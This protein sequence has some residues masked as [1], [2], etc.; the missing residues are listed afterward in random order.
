[1]IRHREQRVALIGLLALGTV[2]V[3]L[4]QLRD[5]IAFR[6]YLFRSRETIDRAREQI[7]GWEESYKPA[8]YLT[9]ALKE[10]DSDGEIGFRA[11]ATLLDDED[12]RV[13]ARTVELIYHH[14]SRSDQ[15]LGPYSDLDVA[16]D[17]RSESQRSLLRYLASE[18]QQRGADRRAYRYF[19]GEEEQHWCWYW[20]G[21]ENHS[22]APTA[23]GID[24]CEEVLWDEFSY[25]G[26]Y[27]EPAKLKRRILDALA[28]VWRPD[29]D[30]DLN[31]RILD[32]LQRFVRTGQDPDLRL[33]TLNRLAARCGV[34][35][36]ERSPLLSDW[37]IVAGF[38]PPDA[39]V[40][41]EAFPFRDEEDDQDDES[42]WAD[43]RGLLTAVL[44]L[45]DPRAAKVVTRLAAERGADAIR[46]AAALAD[47]R[48]PFPKP[49]SPPT[50]RSDENRDDDQVHTKSGSLKNLLQQSPAQGEDAR[51]SE[52][53]AQILRSGERAVLQSVVETAIRKDRPDLVFALAESIQRFPLRKT[54]S[55]MYV[56][57]EMS[58]F[59][60]EDE[61]SEALTT[62]WQAHRDKLTWDSAKRRFLIG[63]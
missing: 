60:D 45:D 14:Y 52:R 18:P 29:S 22:L 38:C 42:T 7:R 37:E 46:D 13:W 32:T 51:I 50:P 15:N 49:E 35:R 2:L 58:I 25:D 8:E 44:C 10:L 48:I 33:H 23:E 27:H 41:I 47:T 28:S 16:S 21:R 26:I 5:S 61:P 59:Q 36:S 11:I 63:P 4:W 20:S 6:W 30:G 17:L 56:E 1:M 43:D 34:T 57:R 62:W 55:A 3:V 24:F 39:S 53:V 19:D 12:P 31:R 9:G 40:A 54:L